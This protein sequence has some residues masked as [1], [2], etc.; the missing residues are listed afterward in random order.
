M[1][2]FRLLPTVE[3][4]VRIMYYVKNAA[5]L[6][7]DHCLTCSVGFS[8]ECTRKYTPMPEKMGELV[9]LLVALGGLT[10]EALL[11]ELGTGCVAVAA[12][13]RLRTTAPRCVH[14]HSRTFPG[15]HSMLCCGCRPSS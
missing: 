5:F 7:E 9:G 6:H 15:L 1:A 4:T 8:P 12:G 3:K 2:S 10:D 11:A 13:C 14:A